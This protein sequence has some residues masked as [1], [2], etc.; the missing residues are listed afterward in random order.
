[1][2]VL[3]GGPAGAAAAR[4]LAVWGHQV[5]LLTR[6]PR[7]PSLAESLTPSCGKLLERIGA[8]DAVTGAGFVRSTGH[9]VQWGKSDA[10]VEM[11]GAGELGWQLLSDSLDRVLLGAAR[12]AGASV[13]RKANVQRVVQGAGGHWRVTYEERGVMRQCLTPWVIDCT[14]R[15]GL[16]SRANSGRVPS[17]PRTVAIVGTW[18]RRPDWS[19]AND[20]HTHVESYPGGW[21]WSVP[22]SRRRRQVTV[23]LDPSRTE[24]AQRRRL[25][26]TYR[27]ELARTSMIRDMTE[28]ARLIRAP[29]ARDASSYTCEIPRRSRL[30]VAGDAASCVDPLSSFGVKKALA[31]GWLAA[32]VVHSVLT[33]ATLED[34]AMTLF[35]AR[36]VAMVT[37]LRR[38]LGEL[39]REAADAHR[40]GFWGDRT[41]L[42]V[43]VGGGDPDVAALRTDPDV[44]AAFEAIRNAELL[45]LVPGVG[46]AQQPRAMVS[47]QTVVLRDHLQVPAFPEGIRYLRNVDLIVLALLSSQHASVPALYEAYCAEAGVVPL[48]DVLGA[49]AVMVG[50]GILRFA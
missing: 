47:G 35:A 42:D 8:L 10:R 34:H 3:G 15:A 1:M 48:A 50:K 14:G 41:G 45:A 31:S 4:M 23:M 25:L 36:E 22:V 39:T 49:L 2:A 29:W 19:L 26:V 16:M 44:R 6:P 33:D 7:G 40:G 28:R 38:Q 24:V 18:E 5:L 21:A 27:G 20:T 13:H 32:V 17:G 9:T 43:V 37:G 46:V 11:F 30:L 12:L